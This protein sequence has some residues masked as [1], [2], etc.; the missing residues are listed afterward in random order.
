MCQSMV[1]LLLLECLS[2]S[3]VF[4]KT[5]TN[6][7]NCLI[8]LRHNLVEITTDYPQHT[9]GAASGSPGCI[10]PSLVLINN[11]LTKLC[12]SVD[13]VLSKSTKHS[14]NTLFAKTAHLSHQCTAPN[15]KVEPTSIGAQRDDSDDDSFPEVQIILTNLKHRYG[16]PSVDRNPGG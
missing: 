12:Q 6:N 14:S 5:W 11:V 16:K 9:L 2:L 7:D 15:K 1:T 13:I 4:D 10:L 3:K 8:K